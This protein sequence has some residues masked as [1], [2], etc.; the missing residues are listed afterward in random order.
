M[1][2]QAGEEWIGTGNWSASVLVQYVHPERIDDEQA[3]GTPVR[4]LGDSLV[5]VVVTK[6]VPDDH[7]P[8]TWLCQILFETLIVPLEDWV[9]RDGCGL[10]SAHNE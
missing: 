6:A 2:L 4:S 5:Y 3:E 9:L 7:Q 8:H 1:R 10:V